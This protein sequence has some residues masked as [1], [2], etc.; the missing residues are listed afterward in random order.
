[1]FEGRIGK[2]VGQWTTEYKAKL[3]L[4][5][6][7]VQFLREQNQTQQ[8][9]LVNLYQQI[10]ALESKSDELKYQVERAKSL[11][12][13]EK[14]NLYR[15]TQ[16][17]KVPKSSSLIGNYLKQKK[18]TRRLIK[19]LIISRNACSGTSWNG[20]HKQMHT[21]RSIERWRERKASPYSKRC[22]RLTPSEPK[23]DNR[24]TSFKMNC[25]NKVMPLRRRRSS[26][27]LV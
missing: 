5:R 23:L 10:Q 21:K 12:A 25:A 27:N 8:G 26:A 9:D 3:G 4:L 16:R 15:S 7:N 2:H 24:K 6:K 17:P 20:S 1:M 13:H 14:K 11:A 19:R 22:E 18:L